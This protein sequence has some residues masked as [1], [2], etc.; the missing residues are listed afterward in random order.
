V[1]TVIIVLFSIFGFIIKKKQLQSVRVISSVHTSSTDTKQQT[2]TFH[3]A[4][5]DEVNLCRIIHVYMYVRITQISHAT[6]T[7]QVSGYTLCTTDYDKIVVITVSLCNE[8]CNNIIQDY[9]A[10]LGAGWQW[11]QSPSTPHRPTCT[12]EHEI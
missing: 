2:S 5:N 1:I 11:I 8:N 7:L 4:Q 3:C 9:V 12:A 6:C 10:F